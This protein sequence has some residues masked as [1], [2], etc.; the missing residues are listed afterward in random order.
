MYNSTDLSIIIPTR[1]RQTYCVSC[2]KSI[3]SREGVFELIICDS[4][5]DDSLARMLSEIND[6]RLRYIR[7][8]PNFNMTENFS[9]ALELASGKYV[10]MIGDDD[11]IAENIFE[12]VRFCSENNVDALSSLDTYLEYNW[13]DFCSKVDG[14]SR[15]G[16]IFI[17]PSRCEFARLDR[18]E[19]LRDFECRFGQGSG[20]M[21]RIYHGLISKNLLDRMKRCYG[22]WFLGVSP[23]VSFSYL[24]TTLAENIWVY[25]GPLSISGNSGNSNAGRSARGTHKGELESDP[26]MKNYRNY[27]WPAIIPRFFSVESVWAQASLEAMDKVKDDYLCKFNFMGLYA[28]MLLKHPDRLIEIKKAWMNYKL[29]RR[30]PSFEFYVKLTRS[31]TH[32]TLKFAR[33]KLESKLRIKASVIVCT[34][35]DIEEASA[36]ARGVE[37]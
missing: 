32:E 12:A 19:L 13:P 17:K 31:V 29:V 34:A 3:L 28:N 16:K 10:I 8:N 25:S 4:S 14:N 33:R 37:V 7:S 18:D 36:C 22:V 11:G 2:I 15:A 27:V 35:N 5:D 30:Q 20:T 23:D 1:N 21:P 26:H 24:A 9:F 6:S